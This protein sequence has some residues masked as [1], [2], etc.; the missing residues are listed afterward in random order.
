ML[1]LRLI[2]TQAQR[3]RTIPWLIEENTS[4]ITY[5][6][7]NGY[8]GAIARRIRF[9]GITL[10]NNDGAGVITHTINISQAGTPSRALVVTPTPLNLP[11]TVGS[12]MLTVTSANIPWTAT[13]TP[14]WVTLDQ[15]SGIASGMVMTYL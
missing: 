1:G 12:T 13:G 6:R 10:R 11:P 4:W 15:S 9:R 5:K 14:A 3:I 7:D 2:R 8:D